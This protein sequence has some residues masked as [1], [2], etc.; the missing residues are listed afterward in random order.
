M[1]VSVV[2]FSVKNYNE[3]KKA[4]EILKDINFQDSKRV[5][6]IKLNNIVKELYTVIDSDCTLEFIT[7]DD[8]DGKK[9]Y[10]HTC[11]HILAQAVSNIFPTVKLAIGPSI[12]NGFYYDFDFVT[13]ISR[14]DFDKIE[15]EMKRIIKANFPIERL[16]YSKTEAEEILL[17]K[18]QTYKLE[19][20][21]DIPEGEKITFYRQ[22]DFQDLCIGAHLTH[23]GKVK[24]FKLT[25]LTGAYWRGSEKNKMLTR[26][27]GTA[28]EKD[29]QLQEYL[30][31]LEEAKQKDHNKLGRELGLFMT[32]ENIGQG[33]ALLMPKGAK[34]IQ[35]LQRFVE[36]EEEKRGYVFTKTPIMTKPNLFITSGH[37]E[38][39]KDKMFCVDEGS[40]DEL[41]MR[42]MTCPFQFSI[43]NNG[44]K[45][46]RDLPIRYSETSTLFRK[47]ASGEMHGLI[48]LRQFTL[49][50]G[51]IV[52][53]KKQ[54]E[55]EFKSTFDLVMFMLKTFKLEEDVTFRFSRWDP[56]DPKKYIGTKKEWEHTEKIMENLLQKAKIQYTDGWGE[57]AFYGPKLDVQI[58]NVFG[59]EDTIITIQIDFSL[60]KKFKMKY[61][62]EKGEEATPL[63]IHRSSIG[64]YERTLAILIEKYNG[65]FPVWFAP[66]QVRIL[67]LTDRCADKVNEYKEILTSK[68]IRV[69]TDLRNEKLGKKIRDA[70]LER[71]PYILIVGDKEA[72]NNSVS[73]R[74]RAEGDLGTMSFKSF[75]ERIEEEIE[76]K[77]S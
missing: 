70:R 47:E 36:D 48:R 27:Y 14:D 56:N 24:A 65:A 57:A 55:S 73:V 16:E 8:P 29:S 76:I 64:C 20:L 50:D 42:P 21:S 66:E 28:F 22:G 40:D 34:V 6:G 12:E 43:Y 10:R 60:A 69:T 53:T 74:Y 4:F 46:Y 59:K 71:V 11:S 30:E 39:Y 61:I 9:M 33:L 41:Y 31:Q 72:E 35:I 44:L 37:L 67:S 1:Q 7:F 45:S 77:K 75:I 15:Q 3:P 25:S 51:H 58:K 17:K 2:G 49:S 18:N 23:T 32:D 54:L 63:I 19:L 13:S 68:K 62:N 38:H 52:C 5:I 26:I